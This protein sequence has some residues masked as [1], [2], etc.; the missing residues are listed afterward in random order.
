MIFRGRYRYNKGAYRPFITLYISSN[1]GEWK[2][3]SFLIDSGADET[4]LHSRSI[5]FLGIDTSAYR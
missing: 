5:Q 2:K 3:Q 1:E 4:F